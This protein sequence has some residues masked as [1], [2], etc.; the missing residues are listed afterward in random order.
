MLRAVA[1]AKVVVGGVGAV[2]WRSQCGC[3]V[4]WCGVVWYGMGWVGL[5][6]I[7]VVWCGAVRFGAA[8]RGVSCG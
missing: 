2:R 3:V 8:R 1:V 4:V 7:G 6:G 5:V